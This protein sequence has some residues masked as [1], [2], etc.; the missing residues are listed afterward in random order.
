MRVSNLTLISRSFQPIMFVSVSNLA[1]KRSSFYIVS[2][3]ANSNL[4]TLHHIFCPSILGWLWVEKVNWKG[5]EMCLNIHTASFLD[6]QSSHW[7][8]G[9]QPVTLK[10]GSFWLEK[11]TQCRRPKL[12]LAKRRSC[13]ALQTSSLWKTKHG[14]CTIRHTRRATTTLSFFF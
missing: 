5:R 12:L 6:N 14:S 4:E 9:N 2:T 13:S 1:I 7:C 11:Y 8:S 10:Y 3:K